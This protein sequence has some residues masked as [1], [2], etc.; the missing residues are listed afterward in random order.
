MVCGYQY[1]PHTCAT[2]TPPLRNALHVRR[3]AVWDT[4]GTWSLRLV[5]VVPRLGSRL[6]RAPPPIKYH[7][8]K[9]MGFED[10]DSFENKFVDWA[11]QSYPSPWITGLKYG[12]RI[13]GGMGGLGMIMDY[14]FNEGPPRG[15]L[16]TIIMD[17]PGTSR[18]IRHPGMPYPV[19][20]PQDPNPDIDFGKD[21][22][23]STKQKGAG[24]RTET[25]T[26]KPGDTLVWD[27][28]TRTNPT[29]SYWL[30]SRRRKKMRLTSRKR[31]K[32]LVPGVFPWI[33]YLQKKGQTEA[34][35]RT[36][37]VLP[38]YRDIKQEYMD[39]YE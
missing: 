7:F 1:Y 12:L 36:N 21:A 24:T 19:P 11:E 30:R 28:M 20:P 37:R 8:Y 31:L 18:R 13:L 3:N 10:P 25:Q 5:P 27:R 35:A 32:R 22:K 33:A 2:A 34:Q 9:T 38:P 26:V 17:S 15:E 14:Y 29:K 4:Y 23:L 16:P 39:Y 6:A